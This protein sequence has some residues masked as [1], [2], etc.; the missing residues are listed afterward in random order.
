MNS[1][2]F[3]FLCPAIVLFSA[4][5]FLP[6]SAQQPQTLPSNY[7][8][9]SAPYAEKIVVA[10]MKRHSSQIQKIGLHAVPPQASDNV[11]IA[12]NLPEKIGKKNSASDMEILAAGKPH[13]LR[14]EK[15]KFFD[16]A[17]PVHDKA[18]R[19]I[20]GGLLVMEVPYADAASE[21]EAMHIGLAIRDELQR[22]IPSKESLYR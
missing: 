15:G 1:Q 18:G 17:I 2:R 21:S 12:S 6:S 16:L 20:G 4:A 5:A 10:A 11:I 3:R 14:D 13:L 9:V 19:D 22:Q 8:R 7:I